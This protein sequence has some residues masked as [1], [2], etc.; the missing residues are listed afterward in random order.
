MDGLNVQLCPDTGI[1]SIIRTNGKKIDLMP[2]EVEQL[3]TVSGK[4]DAIKRALAEVDSSF[5][6]GLDASEIRE[7]SIRL[8]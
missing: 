7:V 4:P 8:R 6:E 5:A 3:R 1:C 2:D